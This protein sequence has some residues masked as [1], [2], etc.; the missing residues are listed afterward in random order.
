MW[1][2]FAVSDSYILWDG[3]LYYK[4]VVHLVSIVATI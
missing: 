3:L 2:K 1:I 4:Y